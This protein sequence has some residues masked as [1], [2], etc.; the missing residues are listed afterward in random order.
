MS[1]KRKKKKPKIKATLDCYGPEK[2]KGK[3]SLPIFTKSRADFD[4]HPE[5]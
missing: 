1:C 5:G 4:G 2:G 3:I